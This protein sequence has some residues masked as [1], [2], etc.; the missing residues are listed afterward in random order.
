MIRKEK[1]AKKLIKKAK[2]LAPISGPTPTLASVLQDLDDLSVQLAKTFPSFRQ[3]N[4]VPDIKTSSTFPRS[5]FEDVRLQSPPTTS[6]GNPHHYHPPT[7]EELPIRSMRKPYSEPIFNADYKA[8]T[9]GATGEHKPL[10]RDISSQYDVPVMR[11]PSPEA[12]RAVNEYRQRKDQEKRGLIDRSVGSIHDMVIEPFSTTSG[13]INKKEPRTRN[14]HTGGSDVHE[15]GRGEMP[16]IIE[17]EER[18]EKTGR[19]SQERTEFQDPRD[20]E[21]GMQRSRKNFAKSSQL[22]EDYY[23][24]VRKISTSPQR[25]TLQDLY[26]HKPKPMYVESG[27]KQTVDR[28]HANA[29][30]YGNNSNYRGN[31][32][33]EKQGQGQN[34]RQTGSSYKHQNEPDNKRLINNAM[35]VLLKKSQNNYK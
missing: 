23:G 11:N 33:A 28:Y 14:A 15:Y 35:E 5:A 16:E 27:N 13:T 9:Y 3:D 31:A 2:I 17:R 21:Y 34:F 20:Y 4:H 32:S 1:V 25:K 7:K 8:G 24:H 19:G 10:H 26:K 18:T 6:Y 29:Q 12:V 30:S 22:A